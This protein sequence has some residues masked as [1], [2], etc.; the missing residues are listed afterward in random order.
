MSFVTLFID[1]V[2]FIEEEWDTLLTSIHGVVPE[3]DSVDQ[4]RE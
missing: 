4:V 1:M 2:S 3:F